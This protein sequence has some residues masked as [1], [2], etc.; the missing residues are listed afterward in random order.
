M[1]RKKIV[2]RRCAACPHTRRTQWSGKFGLDC[3]LT[4]KDTGDPDSIPDWCKLED[5]DGNYRD[6][7]QR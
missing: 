1:R 7:E 6:K 4:N 5:D 2:I 3:S